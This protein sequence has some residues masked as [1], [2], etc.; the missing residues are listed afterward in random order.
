VGKGGREYVMAPVS[1]GRP[2]LTF[3]LARRIEAPLSLLAAKSPHEGARGVEHLYLR[4]SS[5]VGTQAARNCREFS[6]LPSLAHRSS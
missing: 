3:W 4:S 1:I 2:L 5:A 6:G